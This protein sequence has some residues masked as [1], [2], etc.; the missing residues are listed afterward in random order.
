MTAAEAPSLSGV[1]AVMVESADEMAQAVWG[2]LEECDV[3]VMAAAVTD[4]KP[5]VQDTTKIKRDVGLPTV[6]F[7]PTPDVLKGVHESEHRPFLVGFAAETGGLDDAAEKAKRKG[8]DL[9]V[10]NDVSRSGSEFG[11]DTNQVTLFYKDGTSK[12]LPLMDKDD[13]AKI[14]WDEIVVLRGAI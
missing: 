1:E 14:L 11:S 8:V 5:S 10:G 12:A 3:A 6:T 13:V 9:L 4:F 2:R 7:V